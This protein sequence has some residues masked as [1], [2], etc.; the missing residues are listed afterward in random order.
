MKKS[1]FVILVFLSFSLDFAFANGD[2]DHHMGDWDHMFEFSYDNIFMW[3]MMSIWIIL[4]V[5]VIYYLLKNSK[6]SSSSQ[7][8]NDSPLEILRKRYA[9]GE[10]TKEEF[11]KMK[12]DLEK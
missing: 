11:E 3:I 9:K 4:I 5:T 7:S 2:D 12:W 8:L 1:I 6:T 10:I